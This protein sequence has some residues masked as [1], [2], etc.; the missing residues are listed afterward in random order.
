MET[1]NPAS[2]TIIR[3]LRPYRSDILAQKG[4]E[5][6]QSRADSEKTA[7]TIGSG[8]PIDRPMAGST[9]II[10]VFPMAV[11][12]ETA[13]M[14]AKEDRGTPLGPAAAGVDAVDMVG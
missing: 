12:M 9:E 14:I 5:K 4:E 8:I 13:K 2:P 7:A 10:P 11:T 3:G 6:A 1:M